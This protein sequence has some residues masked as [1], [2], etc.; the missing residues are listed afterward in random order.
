[1]AQAYVFGSGAASDV[2]SGVMGFIKSDTSQAM[3]DLQ[4]L[5]NAAPL[6]ARPYWRKNRA[7]ADALAFRIVMLRPTSSGEVSLRSADP[8]EPPVIR[9]NFLSDPAEWATLRQGLRIVADLRSRGELSRLC[10][11]EIDPPADDSDAAL[12]A[13]ISERSL[14]THHPLGTC[15]MGRPDD[16]GAVTGGD[17][18]VLGVDGLHVVDA[19]VMPDMIGGNINAPIIMIAERAAD[20][21]RGRPQL[22]PARL[23]ER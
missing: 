3:P 14:T 13:S 17:L 5:L 1:M 20:M 21:I 15:R 16:E 9:Q 6:N 19:S 2:P 4:F 7:Y 18:R 22:P 11:A 23:V 8:F 12:D 10:G